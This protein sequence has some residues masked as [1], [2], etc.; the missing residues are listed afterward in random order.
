[1]ITRTLARRLKNLEQR[2]KPGAEPMFITVVFVGEN[3]ERTEGFTFQVGGDPREP[4]KLAVTNPE[5]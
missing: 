4:G 2:F 3:G 1:M 5:Q